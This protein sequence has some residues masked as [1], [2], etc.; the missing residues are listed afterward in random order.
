MRHDDKTV[1]TTGEHSPRVQGIVSGMPRSLAAVG[2]AVL[3]AVAI[4]GV[5]ALTLLPYP[6]GGG[7]SILRHI[8]SVIN[9]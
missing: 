5:A 1:S 8:L 9:H 3:A 6:Y 7:K 2:I 4:I